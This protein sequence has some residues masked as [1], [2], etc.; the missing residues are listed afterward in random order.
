RSLHLSPLAFRAAR[1]V[2]AAGQAALFEAVGGKGDWDAINIKKLSA[3]AS[4]TR[5]SQDFAGTL[6][7]ARASVN[8][9]RSRLKDPEKKCGAAEDP[10]LRTVSDSKVSDASSTDPNVALHAAMKQPLLAESLGFVTDWRLRSDHPLS[11]GVDYV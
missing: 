9:I 10:K 11:M 4:E 8:K 1:W 5:A 2:N 7:S 3:L 6:R